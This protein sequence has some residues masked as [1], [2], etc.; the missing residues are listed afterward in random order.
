MPNV[1]GGK[2]VFIGDERCIMMGREALGE[3][4]LSDLGTA[5][6]GTK[7]FVTTRGNIC[8]RFVATE[9]EKLSCYI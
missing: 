4:P 8:C 9:S 5:G 3:Y 7:A 6:R 2:C 1:R